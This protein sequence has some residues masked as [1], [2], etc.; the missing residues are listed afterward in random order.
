MKFKFFLKKTLLFYIKKTF[1]KTNNRHIKNVTHAKCI[2]HH[3]Y[4]ARDS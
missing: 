1:L 2:I 3:D 4:V